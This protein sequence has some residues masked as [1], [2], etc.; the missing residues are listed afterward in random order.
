M[1]IIVTHT[2]N[3]H[4]NCALSTES[5][6]MLKIQVLKMLSNMMK[7]MHSEVVMG[8]RAFVSTKFRFWNTYSIGK[9]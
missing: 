8:E 7:K 6:S 2:P 1:S 3:R 4:F 9:V 5:V